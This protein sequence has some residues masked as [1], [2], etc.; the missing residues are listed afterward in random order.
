MK[1]I[2]IFILVFSYFG[3]HANIEYIEVKQKSSYVELKIHKQNGS[4]HCCPKIYSG[5]YLG[6]NSEFY[7][8]RKYGKGVAMG[9]IKL[10]NERGEEQRHSISI[11]NKAEVVVT[12]TIIIKEPKSSV[13]IYNFKGKRIK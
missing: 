5:E 9:S 2:L 6:H 10:F 3:L 12:N 13:A 8:V 4:T 1:N 7:V 11:G